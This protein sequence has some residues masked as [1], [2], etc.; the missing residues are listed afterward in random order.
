MVWSVEGEPLFQGT[1]LSTEL[2]LDGSF[3]I[4]PIASGDL[5]T[6]SFDTKPLGDRDVIT[7]VVRSPGAIDRVQLVQV[8]AAGNEKKEGAIDFAAGGRIDGPL[9]LLMSEA[10]GS[11]LVAWSELPAG[12]TRP[13]LRVARV[14]CVAQ[15]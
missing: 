4:A 8:D 7:A 12:A 2:I 13:R 9:S 6:T 11:A 15:P 3:S 1:I 5:V 14:D 10:T